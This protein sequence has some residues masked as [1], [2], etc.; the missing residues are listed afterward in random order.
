MKNANV[1]ARE[2]TNEEGRTEVVFLHK[3]SQG[4]ADRSFG[5]HVAQ[6]AG[7][8]ESCLARAEEILRTLESKSRAM[9]TPTEG[10]EKAP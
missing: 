10:K 3:I 5:I 8:P 6:L 7:L 4:P 9:R 1:E 2:W